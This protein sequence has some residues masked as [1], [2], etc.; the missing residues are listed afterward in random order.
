[1]LRIP[2]SLERGG[3]QLCRAGTVLLRFSLTTSSQKANRDRVRDE[4]TAYDGAVSL[5]GLN[6]QSAIVGLLIEKP[7][8]KVRI[9][10]PQPLI[11]ISIN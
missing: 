3:C 5:I 7:E 6:E 9:T 4:W 2:V 10:S 11:D 1:M 8:I